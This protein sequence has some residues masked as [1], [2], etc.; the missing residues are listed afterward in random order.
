M[1]FN[2]KTPLTIEGI[3]EPLDDGMPFNVFQR[4]T[5]GTSTLFNLIRVKRYSNN[6]RF[7]PTPPMIAIVN[8]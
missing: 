3:I 1:A 7:M 4:L 5:K 8:G 2:M 6:S